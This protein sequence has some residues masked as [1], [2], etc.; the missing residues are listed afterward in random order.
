MWV[1]YGLCGILAY[2]CV[3]C[4]WFLYCFDII[5]EWFVYGLCVVLCDFGLVC[6]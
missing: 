4:V 5:C 3:V 6:V 2:L 1:L